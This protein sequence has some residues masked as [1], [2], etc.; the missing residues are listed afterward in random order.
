[1]GPAGVRLPA[2][3]SA[4]QLLPTLTCM[5]RSLCVATWSAAVALPATA[6]AA[7]PEDKSQPLGFPVRVLGWTA[8]AF[9]VVNLIKD[10]DRFTLK[11]LI[12]QWIQAYEFLITS[13]A[14]V[15]F[16]WISVPWMNISAAE[17]HG[18]VIATLLTSSLSKGI[19]KGVSANLAYRQRRETLLN[20]LRLR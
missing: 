5:V 10:L 9:S 14:D 13:I 16:G 6:N 20:G 18:M 12:A 4:G 1:L 19:F 17:A 11:G 7:G 2:A 3:T 15:L 8:A